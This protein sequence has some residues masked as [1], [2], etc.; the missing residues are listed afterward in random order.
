MLLASHIISDEI[1]W[2]HDSKRLWGV[3]GVRGV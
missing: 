1:G 2:G 3:V